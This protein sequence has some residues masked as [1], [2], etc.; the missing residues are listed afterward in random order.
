MLPKVGSI[1]SYKVQLRGLT[2]SKINCLN[3]S[4]YARVSIQQMQMVDHMS[5]LFL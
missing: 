1:T 4:F 3:F 5:S 2:F